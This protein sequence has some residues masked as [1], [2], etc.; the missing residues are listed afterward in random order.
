L[1]ESTRTCGFT[2]CRR[3]QLIRRNL[4]LQ[5]PIAQCVC[6]AGGQVA[7]LGRGRSAGSWH[8]CTQPWF[9]TSCV[10]YIW[11]GKPNVTGSVCTSH[12][13]GQIGVEKLFLNIIIKHYHLPPFW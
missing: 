9:M 2:Q 12:Y 3:T 5:V 11:G 1:K 4:L 10:T 8:S 6:E 13:R 7:T